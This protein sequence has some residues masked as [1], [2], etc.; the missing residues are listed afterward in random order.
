[1]DIILLNRQL[2][3]FVNPEKKFEHLIFIVAKYI[4]YFF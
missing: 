2:E 4:E 3:L 1:M